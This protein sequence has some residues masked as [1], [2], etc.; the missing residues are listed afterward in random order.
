VSTPGDINPGNDTDTDAVEIAQLA[1]FNRQDDFIRKS[2]NNPFAVPGDEVIWTITISNPA[3]IP[4]M[5]V[6][7]K[8][9][10]DS[11]LE[12]L[13]AT[14]SAGTVTTSGQD[15][16]YTQASLA[17]GAS[18]TITIRARVRANAAVPFVITN[19]ASMDFDG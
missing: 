15:I 5:N 17:P 12:L 8:D 10:L 19:A 2:V 11:A 18:V 16:T 6:V 7:V 14:A 9:T 13:S 1:A 4:L 3:V